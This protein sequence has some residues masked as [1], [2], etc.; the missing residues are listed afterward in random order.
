METSSAAKNVL[1]SQRLGIVAQFVVTYFGLIR[2]HTKIRNV[3]SLGEKRKFIHVGLKKKRGR[4]KE[5]LDGQAFLRKTLKFSGRTNKLFYC[6][7]IYSTA[8]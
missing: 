5:T 6:S 2:V 4:R 3:F 8:K 1:K 7:V